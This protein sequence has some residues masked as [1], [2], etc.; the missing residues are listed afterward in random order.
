MKR[1][2]NLTNMWQGRIKFTQ[3]SNPRRDKTSTHKLK[4][5]S[6][7]VHQ[8]PDIF[9]CLFVYSY[10]RWLLKSPFKLSKEL[11][12]RIWR[13]SRF[14]ISTRRRHVD[15]DSGLPCC[16]TRVVH[17]RPNSHHAPRHVET[18]CWLCSLVGGSFGCFCPKILGPWWGPPKVFCGSANVY[19]VVVLFSGGGDTSPL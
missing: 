11:D 3:L 18:W 2:K 12:N 5:F 19:W 17:N 13:R 4:P 16:V 9:H 6:Y 15:F 1:R 7:L 8:L 14:G 10:L